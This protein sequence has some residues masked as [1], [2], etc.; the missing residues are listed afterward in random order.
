MGL[1]LEL[2]NLIKDFYINTSS[3]F[4]T[5]EGVTSPTPILAEVK[6]GCP[7]SPTLL[8]LPLKLLI[9]A[10]VAKVKEKVQE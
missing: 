2:V 5:N 1:P 10:V 8:N 3:P 6:Q 9:S 7:L 4:Q